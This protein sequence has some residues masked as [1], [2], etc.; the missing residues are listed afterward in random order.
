VKRGEGWGQAAVLA[1][2]QLHD[3]DRGCF[4][5]IVWVRKRLGGAEVNVGAEGFWSA[6]AQGACSAAAIPEMSRDI[7]VA[8]G[9]V[10]TTKVSR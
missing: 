9:D 5:F 1:L 6:G 10:M 7:G 4:V 8:A 3:C 2:L